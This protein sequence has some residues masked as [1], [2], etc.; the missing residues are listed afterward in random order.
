[1][2]RPI[3][4]TQLALTR[5]ITTEYL[6]YNES[7]SKASDDV[8]TT[9]GTLEPPDGLIASESAT[10]TKADLSWTDNSTG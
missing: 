7:G 10:G 3:L 5:L 1:M 8:K 4:T 6:A 2:Q 9:T